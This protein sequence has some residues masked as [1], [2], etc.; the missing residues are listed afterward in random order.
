MY[1]YGIPPSTRISGRLIT[2]YRRITSFPRPY[3][4]NRI[5]HQL[6]C[7]L[8]HL[9]N[10]NYQTYPYK[11]HRCA[12]S[13][14]NLNHPTSHHPHPNRSTLTTNSLY[15]RRNQQPFLD[16]QNHRTSMILKL[17]IYRLRRVMLRLIH[18]PNI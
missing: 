1:L 3:I 16:S 15:N 18:N 2:N 11:H 7:T 10:A 4:N 14:D 6:A 9:T 17:R 5:S 8:Y 13:R 12:R